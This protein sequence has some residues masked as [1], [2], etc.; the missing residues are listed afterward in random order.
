MFAGDTCRFR[1]DGICLES[2]Q[3]RKP[4]P[5]TLDRVRSKKIGPAG[6]TA[7]GP[8]GDDLELRLHDV[9]ARHHG[10]QGQHRTIVLALKTAELDLLT[11]RTGR[12]PILCCSTTSRASSIE[13]RNRRFF[14]AV[15][16]HRW[17]SGLPDHH[18]SRSSS[19]SKTTGS[20]SRSQA[21]RRQSMTACA[22]DVVELR[23]ASRLR[24]A[25]PCARA[26]DSLRRAPTA[27]RAFSVAAVES[28]DHGSCPRPFRT[29]RSPSRRVGSCPQS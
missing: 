12:V 19:F 27:R 7:D 9:G 15:E 28:I 5:E 3:A 8:H 21:G 18:A 13:R 14:E 17:R 22:L 4:S 20:I 24:Y 23:K 26:Y 2:I 6:F 1:R 11:E 16:S 10:S 25:L 29:E